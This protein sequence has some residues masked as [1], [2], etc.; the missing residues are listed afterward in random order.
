VEIDIRPTRILDVP[1]LADRVRS[2][3]RDEIMASHGLSPLAG[4]MLAV[5]ASEGPRTALVDGEVMAIFGVAPDDAGAQP[6][7]IGAEGIELFHVPF[8]RRSRAWVREAK[9][10]HGLLKNWV[11]ARNTVSIRWLGWLGFEIGE[12]QPHGFCRL[13]FHPFEMR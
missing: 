7:L 9:A 3:D 6:W 2:A 8:L 13:P 12:A 10:R 5:H 4:L 1:A 11:D